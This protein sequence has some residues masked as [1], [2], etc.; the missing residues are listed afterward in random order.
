MHILLFGKNGQ[1]G[2][3]LN[4]SLLPL[5]K[6]SAFDKEDLDLS[7]LAAVENAILSLRPDIIINASAYTAVDRAENEP[8]LAFQINAYAPEIMAKSANKIGAALIHFS[9]DY[10]FDGTKNS[11]YT[12]TDQPNPINVYGKSKLL[13]EN[14][15]IEN[16]QAT[17]V[18]RTSWVYGLS[19]E[20]FAQK[21]LKWSRQQ[22]TLQIVD[23]QVGS[24]TWARQLA[25]TTM[26]LLAQSRGD[27]INY[28]SKRKGVYHL[29]GKGKSSRIEFARQVLQFDP[30]KAEQVYENLAPARTA[31][32]P[33]PAKRPLFTALDCSLFENTFELSI[34]DW[35]HSL[36]LAITA[37]SIPP[38]VG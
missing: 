26:A 13:G 16:L 33:T 34:P 27:L 20:S 28:I 6:I 21:V 25:E 4:R 1:L 37:I 36:Q 22:K 18:L 12:E 38:L 24:P 7:N 8:E 17:L 29:A 9:T 3:E 2:Y 11:L 23:D 5:G 32:F 14:L 31:D 15:V 10:V 35:Q 30:K 19:Q